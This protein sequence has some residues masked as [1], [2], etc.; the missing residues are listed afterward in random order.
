MFLLATPAVKK[1]SMFDNEPYIELFFFIHIRRKTIYYGMNWAS[2]GAAVL[3]YSR[4]ESFS[5][6]DYTQRAVPA[7]QCARIHDAGGV[8]REDHFA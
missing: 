8:W 6:L 7:Q 3:M 5:F 2:A 1:T 4:T